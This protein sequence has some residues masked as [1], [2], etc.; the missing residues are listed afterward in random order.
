MAK[1]EQVFGFKP[2]KN[3]EGLDVDLASLLVGFDEL[4]VRA[5]FRSEDVRGTRGATLRLPSG[6]MIGL[7]EHPSPRDF[8]SLTAAS[9]DVAKVG[10]PAIMEE[11]KRAV[12]LGDH[13]IEWVAD[14]EQARKNAEDFI[15]G[16]PFAA[17]AP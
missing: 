7:E 17:P 2:S 5:G 10:A 9:G 14:T 6:A 11:T 1:L 8:L 3:A 15:K 13:E 16:P 12:H 4:A